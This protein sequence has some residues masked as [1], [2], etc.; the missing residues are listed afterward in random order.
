MQARHHH[1]NL[2]AQVDAQAVAVPHLYQ[3]FDFGALPERFTIA[4][5]ANAMQGLETML[6][7]IMAD[8]ALIE[9]MAAYTMMGDVVADAYA[10][11]IPEFGFRRLIDMLETACE[12][13]VEAVPETRDALA[14]FVGG[15]KQNRD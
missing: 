1:S 8:D 4:P 3:R 13:G 11:C 2:W 15:M 12:L 5:D 7:E 10:A 9:L 6:P 14:A